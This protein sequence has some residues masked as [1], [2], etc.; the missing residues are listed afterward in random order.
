MIKTHSNRNEISPKYCHVGNFLSYHSCMCQGLFTIVTD[1]A[2]MH[3]SLLASKLHLAASLLSF[4]AA[5]FRISLF[6][7]LNIK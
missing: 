1:F 6:I 4:L 3:L 2:S 5:Y 7:T